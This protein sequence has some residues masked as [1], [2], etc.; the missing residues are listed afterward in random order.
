MHYAFAAIGTRGDVQPFVALALGLKAAGHRTTII[1]FENFKEFVTGYGLEFY[2]LPGN[3]E[4]ILYSEEGRKVLASGNIL[5]IMKYMQ[6]GGRK[7]LEEANM[8]ALAACATADVLVSS[9]LGRAS[10][11]SI[12]EKL[13]RKWAVVDLGLPTASTKELPFAGLDYLDFPLYNRFTYWLVQ[14]VFWRLN[15]K[16]INDFRRSIG[17]PVIEK[18]LIEVIARKKILNLYAV[19]TA[20]LPRPRDWD[21]CIDVTGYLF[22][23]EAH[24]KLHAM[25][26]IPGELMAWLEKGE[27]P[28]YIGF[29]S[30]PVP[31]PNLFGNILNEMIARG[32]NRFVFCQGWSVLPDVS[33]GEDLFIIKSI[34]HEWLLPRC[35]A[36]VIH[37]GAGTLAA[38]LRAGIPVVVVSIFGDQ[39]WWGKLLKKKKLGVHIPFGKIST[40][41]LLAALDLAQSPERHTNVSDIGR[42]INREDG[43]QTAIQALEKYFRPTVD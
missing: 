29:G 27:K 3:I 8:H 35:K 21:E 4:Q 17:L 43:L 12:A 26:Q 1:A 34:N 19:S 2:P 15:K 14:Y 5:T 37:G 28:V 42:K 33:A 24:R 25:D 30:M 20:V 31:D 13:N 40:G 22:I 11:L 41:K 38:V 9:I 7:I 18:S 23:P 32:G 39:P 6:K 36:A 10:A 16:D